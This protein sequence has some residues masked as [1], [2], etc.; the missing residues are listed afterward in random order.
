MK[1]PHMRV[2]ALSSTKGGTGKTTLTSSLAVRA[3]QESKRVALID[4]DPQESLSAWI[5][6]RGRPKNPNLVELDAT[7]EAIGLLLREGW[8]WVFIDT[9]PSKIEFIEPGIAAANLV[10]IPCRPSPMDVEQIGIPMELCAIHKKPFAFVL[11]HA[12]AGKL[13]RSTTDWLAPQ[14][15]VLQ[16]PI[17]FRQAYMAAPGHGKTAAEMKDEDKAAAEIDALWHAV[18]KMAANAK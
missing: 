9:S 18:K 13:T 5:D 3:A 8:E 16:P 1:R 17:P 2:I 7:T 12:P 14:G 6:R 4:L 11:N 15:P 10:L